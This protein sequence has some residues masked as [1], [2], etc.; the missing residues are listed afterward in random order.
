MKISVKLNARFT[1]YLPADAVDNGADIEI[2]QF[3]SI[4]SVLLKLNLPL[5]ECRLVL[6]NGEYSPPA[7]RATHLLN[8][9]DHIA[10]WPPLAGG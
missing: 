6:L 10:V 8:E 1:R 7:E 3:S 9:G 4:E 5:K 2:D